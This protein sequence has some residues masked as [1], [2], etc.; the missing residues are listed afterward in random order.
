MEDVAHKRRGFNGF[1]RVCR[2]TALRILERFVLLLRYG[3]PQV[4]AKH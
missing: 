1:L 3:V 2:R 4:W